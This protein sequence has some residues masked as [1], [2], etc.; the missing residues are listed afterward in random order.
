MKNNEL[1]EKLKKI[2]P[3]R[4]D[5]TPYE[6]RIKQK[7][8]MRF[9]RSRRK[10]V[11]FGR[12]SFVSGILVVLFFAILMPFIYGKSGEVSLLRS[13]D[14]VPQA[15]T[16]E[17]TV[18]VIENVRQPF[19][20]DKETRTIWFIGKIN[21][22]YAVFYT[23]LSN[24]KTHTISPVVDNTTGIKGDIKISND[25]VY[26]GIGDYLYIINKKTYEVSV[27]QLGKERYPTKNAPHPI[28]AILP[29]AG[30]KILIS[31]D[32]AYD[33][34][35]YN[36][37]SYHSNNY[38]LPLNI[39]SPF[40]IE[41]GNKNEA[42][43]V[44]R[45]INSGENVLGTINIR[46]RRVILFD[47]VPATHIFYTDGV[48]A[49]IKNALFKIDAKNKVFHKIDVETGKNTHYIQG[50][51]GIYIISS[52]EKGISISKYVPETNR[53]I[54]FRGLPSGYKQISGIIEKDSTLF[55]IVSDKIDFAN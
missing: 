38:R 18:K 53:L 31:R 35:F 54:L 21:N 19:V 47:N 12:L 52:S 44:T 36:T 42:Y 1:V 23:D 29:L 24:G 43:F 4:M 37:V 17:K 15:I 27:V 50:E 39:E 40:S 10:K 46:N 30:D 5:T 45:F 32:N 51:D 13:G 14:I 6:S 55:L 11:I 41:A 2:K 9:Q 48:F 25:K 16:V 20:Y 28:K 7:I 8:E 3:K 49:E 34:I 22:S 26:A 33:I